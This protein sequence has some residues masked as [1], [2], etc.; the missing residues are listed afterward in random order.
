MNETQYSIGDL[1]C[2]EDYPLLGMKQRGIMLGIVSIGPSWYRRRA[3]K[4]YWFE[5]KRCSYY[6]E[7][8]MNLRHTKL[9]SKANQN[10]T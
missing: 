7:T 3:I 5:L 1:I 6:D 9:L 4:V 10:K 8:G 2:T